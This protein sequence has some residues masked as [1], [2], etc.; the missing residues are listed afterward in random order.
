MNR[1]KRAFIRRWKYHTNYHDGVIIP[2]RRLYKENRRGFE[3]E[4]RRKDIQFES[5]KNQEFKP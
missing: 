4:A 5:S 2:N 3:R 1:I